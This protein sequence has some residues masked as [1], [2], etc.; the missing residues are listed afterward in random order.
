[1][2]T[3]SRSKRKPATKASTKAA[4]NI[5]WF[6][7]PADKPERA[8]TFYGKLFGWAIN[9]FPGMAD[10]WH[11]DTGGGDDTPDAGLMA[12]KHPGQGITNYVRVPSVTRFA[13]RVVKLGGRICV[14]R[15]AVPGMGYFVICQ[16][17]EENTFALWEMNPK[18]K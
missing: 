7:I 17:T 18:A 1:M 12:R 11:V 3:A 10:Y 15:T 14:P 9:P 4:H 13:A 8:R 6:E 16:D 2:S 5:I